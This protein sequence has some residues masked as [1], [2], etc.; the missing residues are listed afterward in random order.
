MKIIIE[1]K[2]YKVTE[3]LGFQGGTYAKFVETPEGERVAIKQ[4]GV[5]KWKLI[6]SKTQLRSHCVGM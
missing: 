6:K 3:S 4:G 1:G 2:E 5:W